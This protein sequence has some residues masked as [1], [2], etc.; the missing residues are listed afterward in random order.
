MATAA[1]MQAAFKA[2]SL[3]RA[4]RRVPRSLLIESPVL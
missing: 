4:R 1:P 3:R 2:C